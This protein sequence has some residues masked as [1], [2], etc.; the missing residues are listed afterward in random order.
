MLKR[1]GW[2][3]AL[4]GGVVG[5]GAVVG[6][7]GAGIAPAQAAAAGAPKAVTSYAFTS[8]AGD[9][10]GGGAKGSYTPANATIAVDGTAAGFQMSVSTAGEDWTIML[11]APRGDVLRPG[12]YAKAEEAPIRTGHAPGL[13][14]FGDGRACSDV[15][16]QFSIDQIATDPTTGDVTMLDATFTQRCSPTAPTLKGTVKYQAYP[17]SFAYASDPGDYIG[18]GQS[19]GYNGANSTFTLTGSADGVLQYGISGK[20]DDWSALIAPPTGQT[21]A[22]G[23]TYPT[24]D[25]GGAGVARL[26]FFGDGRGCS[27]TGQLTV[28]K[29]ATDATGKVTA[30]AAT[31]DQHCEG[32]DPALH[33]TIHYLA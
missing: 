6:L 14:V 15:Y 1:Q 13:F 7:L 25:V 10:V 2:R 31:F 9:Y 22:A 5:M 21:L 18:G 19:V 12:V 26:D 30:L 11:A 32:G 20:R 29:L 28:T 27:S 16:G 23:Q 24:T 8:A 17:L 33:G 3:R 4:M